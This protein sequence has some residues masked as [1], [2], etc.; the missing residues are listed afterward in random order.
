MTFYIKTNEIKAET[1]QKNNLKLHL[2]FIKRKAHFK[3]IIIHN[4][5]SPLCNNLILLKRFLFF[6][7]LF[8]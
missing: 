3:Q 7:F 2:S 6:Y 1:T 5:I 8:N 4:T